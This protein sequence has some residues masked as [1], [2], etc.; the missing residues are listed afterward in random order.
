MNHDST[1]G[2]FQKPEPM[3]W[4]KKNQRF[5]ASS[6]MHFTCS[7]DALNGI[8]CIARYS[9]RLGVVD[10]QKGGGGFQPEPEERQFDKQSSKQNF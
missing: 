3:R 2:H 6:V 9:V 7:T 1:G 5:S 8:H 4:G 10:T